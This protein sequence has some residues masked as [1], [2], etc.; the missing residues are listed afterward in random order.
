M[1]SGSLKQNSAVQE[2]ERSITQNLMEFAQII[3][4]QCSKLSDD[5]YSEK[6]SEVRQY[7]QKLTNAMAYSE[8]VISTQGTQTEEFL[9]KSEKKTQ[10][11]DLIKKA[12]KKT[13][14]EK[15]SK[16]RSTLIQTENPKM[17][18]ST[19]Q[20]ESSTKNVE[21]QADPI[22]KVATKSIETQTEAETLTVPVKQEFIES[23][24]KERDHQ[25]KICTSPKEAGKL[26]S[27]NSQEIEVTPDIHIGEDLWPSS[28]GSDA[29]VG[30][31]NGN[32]EN[33]QI[34]EEPNLS[35][36]ERKRSISPDSDTCGCDSEGKNIFVNIG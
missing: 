20:F 26:Q 3:Q 8:Q 13:Q 10:T 16:K 31:V 2:S 24:V 5:M 25:T 11:Q 12:E 29:D 7:L 6:M 27:Y 35:I 32:W 14:T 21:I 17:V 22:L 4:E 36:P 28:D 18:N 1:S 19:T 23:E 15:E 30:N 9:K 33:I 34:M